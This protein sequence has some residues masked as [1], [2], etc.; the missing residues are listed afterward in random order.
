[1]K[2]ILFITTTLLMLAS[3][4]NKYELKM[5]RAALYYER[6]EY[7]SA[8]LEYKNVINDHPTDISSL[9]NNTI[10]MLA[11]AHH[12]LAVIHLKRAY[13]SEDAVEKSSYLEQANYEAQ[14]AYYLYP[15]DVYKNTMDSIK[16]EM[17]L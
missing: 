8:M 9:D 2:K 10:H 3:C 16:R 13:K 11:N 6:G 1:M 4:G 15:M 17:N 7:E 14:T 12:N 5:D